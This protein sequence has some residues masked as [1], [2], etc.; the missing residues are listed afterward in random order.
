LD[1]ILK[2]AFT[3]GFALESITVPS[4]VNG[5][6]RLFHQLRNWP[7]PVDSELV[8]IDHYAVD[9]C[10]TLGSVLLPSSIPFGELD[11]FGACDLVSSLTFGSP[12]R[13]PELLD[14]AAR[15]S[16][17]VAILDSVEILSL[18]ASRGPR[19]SPRSRG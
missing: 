17:V 19:G 7:L 18:S 10:F 8:P 2:R 3:N 11:C 9:E 14:L 1:C 6:E 13:H 4:T 15:L 12:S 5:L 16:G